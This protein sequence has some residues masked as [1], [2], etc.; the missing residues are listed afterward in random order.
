MKLLTVKPI[1]WFIRA[2]NDCSLLFHM[3]IHP[4]NYRENPKNTGFGAT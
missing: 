1:F 2:P 4:L 3:Q